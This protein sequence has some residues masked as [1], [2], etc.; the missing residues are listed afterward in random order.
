MSNVVNIN[1]NNKNNLTVN[2]SISRNIVVT[3]G[4]FASPEIKVVEP[5]SYIATTSEG[6]NSISVTQLVASGSQQLT[7]DVDVT[8]INATVTVTNDPTPVLTL[9]TPGPT[10]AQGPAGP[11]GTIDGV[12]IDAFVLTSSFNPFTASYYSDSASFDARINAGGGGGVNL[13][14]YTTTSSFNAFTSSY[15]TGSFT[16]SFRGTFIGTS[17][18]AQS[19]SQAL[20]AS[21]APNYV[22]NSATSSFILNS[23]TGS[24]TTTSSFNSFTSSYLNDSSSFNTRIT[25][26]T[27]ATSSYV[28]N[29]QTGVFA[30][31]GSNTFTGNQIINGSLTITNN[32]TV[33]GSSSITYISQSTLNIGTNLITV[34]TNTPSIR[35]GGLAVIDSGSSP[36]RSGSILFDSLN[37]QWIFVHES[38]SGQVTSS[39]FI[40]G[41]QTFNNVGNEGT[42][43]TNRLTKGTGGDLGEHIGDSNITDTGTVVSINSNTEITGSLI[44]GLPLNIASGDYSHAEG[45]ITK[46]IGNY[47]HAEGDNTQAK[48]EYS[49]AEGQETI[50]SGSYSHAEGYQ[51]ITSAN[52]QHVQGQWNA[53]SSV[54]SAFIIGNGADDSN[55]SN[56]VFAAGNI[57]QITGSLRVTNGITGSLFGTAS[58]AENYNETDPVFTSKSGSFTTTSSFN[59]F[60]SSYNTGSFTGSFTGKLTGTATTASYVLQAVSSSYATTASYALS[61]PGGGGIS[62]T[63]AIAYAVALG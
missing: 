51:T 12:N 22:L 54:Q 62:E 28:L 25:N 11:P 36:Q 16:G 5:I 10:G 21:F 27:N 31:T 44:Q 56:L 23:Q 49:H 8:S 3:Q 53:T 48:G 32:L 60:T 18:W 61:S 35:Y 17:S 45:S 40:Q 20:T 6:T 2:D 55:R 63:L 7:I 1:E 57:F 50:A 59:S 47:S 9:N 42:I 38:V 43:T 29:S 4:D 37:N 46:A 39:V 15:T 14:G 24:F 41:P 52:Y 33:L 26:L 19:S 13:S 34:N 30:T 58:W